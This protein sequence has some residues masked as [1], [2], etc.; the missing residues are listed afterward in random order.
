MQSGNMNPTWRASVLILAGLLTFSGGR[1]EAQAPCT[2]HPGDVPW[3]VTVRTGDGSEAPVGA[4]G[5]GT[6]VGPGLAFIPPEGIAYCV[7]SGGHLGETTTGFVHVYMPPRELSVSTDAITPVRYECQD[8]PEEGCSSGLQFYFPE[9]DVTT[10]TCHESGCVPQPTVELHSRFGNIWGFVFGKDGK[11]REVPLKGATVSAI[12]IGNHFR[13]RSTKT[14]GS[15][16][17]SFRTGVMPVDDEDQGDPPRRFRPISIPNANR[18]GLRIFRD[19]DLHPHGPGRSYWKVSTTKESSNPIEVG[20][21]Q[22]QFQILHGWYK[23]G[24]GDPDDRECPAEG[25][26]VTILTG[27]VYLDHVDAALAGPRGPLVFRRSYNSRAAYR[28]ASSELGRGWAHSW[29]AHIEVDTE[30]ERFLAYVRADGVTEYLSD[31]DLDGTFDAYAPPDGRDVVTRTPSGFRRDDLDGTIETFDASGRL[32]SVTDPAGA[33]TTLGY[34]GT[35]LSSIEGPNGR[36]L[37]LLYFP[38]RSEL[39]GPE[40]L[41]AMYEMEGDSLARVTYADATGYRFQYDPM[42]QLLL[43]TDLTGQVVER[44]EYEGDRGTLSEVGDGQRRFTFAYEPGRTTVTDGLGNVTRYDWEGVGEVKRVT[45]VEGPCGSCGSGMELQLKGYDDLGRPISLR[46]ALGEE[47]TLHYDAAGNLDELHDGSGRVWRY[48]YDTR[49]RLTKEIR[50]GGAARQMSHGAAGPLT[51]TDALSKSAHITYTAGGQVETFTDRRG[52]TTTFSYYPNGD[53]Q[54]VRDPLGHETTFEYDA[55]GRRTRVSTAAGTT[56]TTYDRRGRVQKVEGPEGT[57]VELTYD[58][59]GR[60]EVVKDALGRST[61]RGYDQAGRLTTTLDPAGG[62]TRYGY[63]SMS[64][65]AS[66]TD[67]KGQTTTFEHDGYGRVSKTIYPGGAFESYTY[68]G[69]G[70][71]KTKTDRKNVVTTY[72]YDGAGRLLGLVFS[73]GTPAVS[74][75]YDPAGRLWTAANGSDSLTFAYDL[76]GRLLSESSSRN[77][78]TV[79]VTYD[80]AGNRVSLSLD[81][82]L[83]MAYA[84][85][86]NGR[87]ESETQGTRVFNFGYDAADRRTSLSYPNG[88]VTSYTYDGASR[89][90][91]LR[92]SLGATTVTDFSYTYDVVGNRLA[93]TRPEGTEGYGYDALDRLLK[94]ERNWGDTRLWSYGY[95][96]VGNRLKAQAGDAVSTSA[97][98]VRNQLLTQQGGG[99]LLWRGILDEPGAVTVTSATVNGEPARLLAG[100]VFEADVPTQPGVNSV[101]LEARDTRGNVRA[102][103][104]QLEVPA[105]SATYTYD[106]NGSLSTKVDGSGSWTYEWNALGQLVR[107][108]KDGAEVARF[109]YDAV[110][111]R[112]EKLAGGVTTKYTYDGLDILRELV[113]DSAGTYVHGPSIDEPLARGA[114]EQWTYLH[115]DGLGSVRRATAG[116]GQVVTAL[117]RDYDAWGVPLSGGDVPG[118]AYTGREWDP[119]IGLHYYRARYYDPMI[120]RFVSEDPI[121]FWGGVNFFAYVRNNPPAYVDPSGLD[122]VYSQSSGTMYY[123]P[124][125]GVAYQAVGTGYAGMGPGYNNPS[126]ENVPFQGP[127]PGG[128]WQ[129]GPAYQHPSKGPLTMNIDPTGNTAT[130]GRTDFRI[131]GDNSCMC[132]TA[133]EGC[134]VLGPS[135]RKTI[136][137]TVAQTGDNTLWV[138]AGEPLPPG[139]P[140]PDSEIPGVLPPPTPYALPPLVPPQQ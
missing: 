9:H 84:W 36:T 113:G 98:D 41:I 53:L 97:Y 34:E 64:R 58:R 25:E 60:L 75:T 126:M 82:Q 67:A 105:A 21:N 73:D 138:I 96:S 110:G 56:R 137:Q 120:G 18:W 119:E 124:G 65:L 95:D 10:I 88:V 92:A 33:T 130:H 22:E 80:D 115:A 128:E 51:L 87:L 62:V 109:A 70:R 81:G 20:S 66:L 24:K 69:A 129:I 52:K 127:I 90:T 47:T 140:L 116:S 57:R 112:V 35:R 45:R 16:V 14:D 78:S 89:L 107:V 63:D 131:H 134:I 2:Q 93:V 32:L 38:D 43:A 85:D 68:D 19:P 79:S 86:D 123:S 101:T 133:S 122:W 72:S 61:R 44:H 106:A 117:D 39:H 125:G 59:A 11:G 12:E 28:G 103:T 49:G 132:R 99:S 91:R 55:I 29:S 8:Y 27:N 3:T 50:P 77:A 48:E 1:V 102:N 118:H 4:G 31:H 76:N 135:V 26:P 17:F 94:V 40:G 7:T 104:Y 114:D 30:D 100:N 83:H 13:P 139:K 74:Y 5:L 54:K 6:G 15:G 46:N 42:G 136:A 108:V 71:L 121:G 111:R 37:S 23:K